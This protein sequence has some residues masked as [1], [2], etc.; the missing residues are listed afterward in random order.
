MSQRSQTLLP[1]TASSRTTTSTQLRKKRT[2]PGCYLSQIARLTR[3]RGQPCTCPYASHGTA[4]RHALLGSSSEGVQGSPSGLQPSCIA[5]RL[6]LQEESEHPAE[7]GCPRGGRD[8]HQCTATATQHCQLAGQPRTLG[9]RPVACRVPL[10]SVWHR[11]RTTGFEPS[12]KRPIT[13][14]EC[15][16]IRPYPVGLSSPP[17][18]KLKSKT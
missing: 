11:S 1:V 15:L 10:P 4:A 3:C 12:E 16:R 6:P 9:R 14:A 2:M 8:T 5:H 18:S 13:G 7:E 17:P